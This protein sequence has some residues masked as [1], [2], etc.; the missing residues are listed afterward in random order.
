MIENRAR[1]WLKIRDYIRSE[2]TESVIIL[3]RNSPKSA[4]SELYPDGYR[5]VSV[6]RQVQLLKDSIVFRS[7][8]CAFTGRWVMP[9]AAFILSLRAM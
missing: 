2:I 1:I 7:P 6:W 5:V 9:K 8:S 4:I 3:V